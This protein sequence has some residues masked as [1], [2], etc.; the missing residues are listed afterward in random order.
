[1]NVKMYHPPLPNDSH[2]TQ[3]SWRVKPEIA[4]AGYFFDLA[5][6]CID[7][8]NFFFGDAILF[9]GEAYNQANMYEAEDIVVAALLFPNQVVGNAVWCFTASPQNR[10]DKVEIVG[11]SGSLEFSVFEQ[12]PIQLISVERTEAFHYERIRTIQQPLIETI[13]QQLRGEGSCPSTG[14]TAIHTNRIMNQ[15][16]KNYYHA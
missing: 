13:V 4:G 15:I 8:L 9:A 1:M 2:P 10:T 6:H 7:I 5:S 11:S 12:N 3:K 16:V 14:T